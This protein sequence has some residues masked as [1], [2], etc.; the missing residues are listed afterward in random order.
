MSHA[1]DTLKTAMREG[2][3]FGARLT[4]RLAAA[5]SKQR[6]GLTVLCYHRILPAGERAAYYDPGLAVTPTS[7]GQ[8]CRL[9]ADRFHVLPFSEA[10]DA[11][12]TGAPTERPLAAITFDDGY[13]DNHHHAAPILRE[14]GLRATF[15]VIGG[16]VGS[17]TLPWYDE[18]GRA[19]NVLAKRGEAPREFPSAVA[20]MAAVKQWNL[21]RR[22]QWVHALSSAARLEAP[23]TDDLIMT[24]Q[25]LRALANDGHEIG[26]HSLTHPI[27]TQ[28][29]GD[30]LNEE[31]QSSREKLSTMIGQ[32]VR[33]F[34]Y[35]NGNH[36]ARTAGAVAQ[37]GYDY[38][39]T[40]DPG[41]N[42]R[43]V[44]TPLTVQ[45]WFVQEDR[46][47]SLTGAQSPTLMRLEWSG[48]A[49]TLFKRGAMGAAPA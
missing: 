4:G 30:T 36:D 48:L 21:E 9:L 46:L 10:M 16:L 39:A 19:W 23:A 32:P 41:I 33:A 43:D 34:C 38:A 14:H 27:M 28:C 49:D 1:K 22:L 18:A 44:V 35:P 42:A 26:S 7:F 40:M 5:E 15:F 24:P 25:Q 8:H 6:S 45:R 29:D 2:A 17:N 13:Q 31:L 12:R 47:R 37:A 3:A 11:W 20:A